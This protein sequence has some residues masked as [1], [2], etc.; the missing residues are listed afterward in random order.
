MV[1]PIQPTDD[2]DN[3]AAAWTNYAVM[4]LGQLKADEKLDVLYA[5]FARDQSDVRVVISLREGSIILEGVNNA[6]LE[7]G[8]LR[9]I[10]LYR[11]EV[12]P[13]RPQS[14]FGQPDTRTKQ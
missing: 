10:E 12:G 8:Q 1:E 7:P 6:N 11:E 13:F 2:L 14:G 4:C 9:C 5:C 3:A